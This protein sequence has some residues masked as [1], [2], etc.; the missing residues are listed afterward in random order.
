M[1]KRNENIDIIKGI[2][3]ILMV[4]G[5]ADAPFTHFIY[6]FHMQFFIA[7]GYC[8]KEKFTEFLEVKKFVIR[9]FKVYGFLCFMDV[10]FSILNNFLLK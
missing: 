4:C 10:E 3:I 1:K 9:R 7:S 6:L 5:H 2:G 8:F